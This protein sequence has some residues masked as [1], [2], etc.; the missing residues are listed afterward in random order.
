ML[1]NYTEWERITWQEY[2]RMFC[3]R[4]VELLKHSVWHVPCDK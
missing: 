4:I 1:I 2:G 3:S